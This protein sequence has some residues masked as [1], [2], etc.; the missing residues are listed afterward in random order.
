[1][2]VQCDLYVIDVYFKHLSTLQHR[3]YWI[4]VILIAIECDYKP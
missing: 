4:L 1:M 2:C 3:L